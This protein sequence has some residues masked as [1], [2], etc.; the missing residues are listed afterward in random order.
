MDIKKGSIVLGRYKLCDEVGNGSFGTVFKAENTKTDEIVAI[1]IEND[2][3]DKSQEMEIYRLLAGETGFPHIHET[4]LMEGKR[5]VVMEHLGLSLEDLFKFCKCRFTLKTVLMIGLQA[6]NR[7]ET[8]H[9]KGIIHRDIKPDNFLIGYG[10][11]KSKIYLIDFGLSKFYLRDGTH[12]SYNRTSNFIG[13][14]RYSSIRNHRG[15]EQSRRDDLE[16]LAYM[17]IYFLRGSLPWQGQKGS[18]K[19][20]RS[21][22]IYNVKRNVSLEELCDGLPKEFMAF[23]KH[24]RLLDF[25][26]EPDYNHLRGLLLSVLKQREYTYDH[27]YDWNLIAQ[28]RKKATVEATCRQESSTQLTYAKHKRTVQV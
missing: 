1:K 21:K 27:I 19:S 17:L 6:L 22:A 11:N 20:R 8:L 13:S 4:A 24:C 9:K 16:S 5:V 12:S 10:K 3:N 26:Q 18:T 14:Y 25:R 23:V 7:I 28:A 2:S 15:I